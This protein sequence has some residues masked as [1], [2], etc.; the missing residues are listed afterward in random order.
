MYSF[1]QP[2]D[3]SVSYDQVKHALNGLAFPTRESSV[4]NEDQSARILAHL[5]SVF[6]TTPSLPSAA[7]TQ[8]ILREFEELESQYL[9]SRRLEQSYLRQFLFSG[10]KPNA[11]YAAV[12]LAPRSL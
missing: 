4:P 7:M 12:L 1:N 8:R 2:V 5:E 10:A 11:G 3:V 9:A 6:Y